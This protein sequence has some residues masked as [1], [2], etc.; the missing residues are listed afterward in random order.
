MA[1]EETVSKN[2]V[3]NAHKLFDM[4]LTGLKRRIVGVFK[5]KEKKENLR[6]LK[7]FVIH[8]F[9]CFKKQNCKF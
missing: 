6:K 5:I 8:K 7:F 2:A 4:I 1:C 3:R 9:E